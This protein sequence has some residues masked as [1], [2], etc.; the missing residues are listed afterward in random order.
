MRCR[1]SSALIAKPA[2]MPSVRSRKTTIA[3][4]PSKTTASPH[5][6]RSKVANSCFSAMFQRRP[7]ACRQGGQRNVAGERRRGDDEQQ[8]ED[9]MQ[10]ARHRPARAG[11]NIG[12]RAGNR[13]GDTNAAEKRARDI[14][15]ALSDELAI[16]AMT[17][18]GHAVGDHRRK[19][20]LDAAEQSKDSADGSIS[21]N[22]RAQARA[23]AASQAA[24]MPPKRVPMVS[25][26]K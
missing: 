16:G 25:I 21:R 18:A 22:C 13:T 8:D 19:Q 2:T 11:A 24:G 26:G 7:P 15:E 5:E 1:K 6:A 23:S 12:G 3:K 20:A 10:H 4:V 17:A 9:G 14:G